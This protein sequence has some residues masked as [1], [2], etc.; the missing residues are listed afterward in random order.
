TGFVLGI[1]SVIITTFATLVDASP[2]G[3]IY[4]PL[5]SFHIPLFLRGQISPNIG[6]LLGLSAYA[7]IAIFYAV[8]L[9]GIAYL[10]FSNPSRVQN[11]CCNSEQTSS[12]NSST[13]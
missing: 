13:T 3:D 7:S 6:T 5:V 2:P 12:F 11:V 8:L 1:Y 4:N 9:A 10:W